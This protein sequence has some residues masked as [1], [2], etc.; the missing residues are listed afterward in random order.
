MGFVGD[1]LFIE[2]KTKQKVKARHVNYR[3]E[4]LYNFAC[5]FFDP[6]IV[7]LKKELSSFFNSLTGYIVI[8]VFLLINSLFLWVFPGE[9]NVLDSGYA[10][11]ETLFVL[12]PWVFLFLVPAVCMRL[13]SEEKRTGTIELIITRPLSELQVVLAKYLAG[14]GLVLFSLL[15][16]LIYFVSVY[17]LGNPV[18][19]ID[20][21]ATW[22]SYIGLFFLAG[23]YTSIGVFASSLTENQIVAFIIAM[24]LSFFFFIGFESVSTLG[25]FGKFDSFLINLGINEHYRSMSRGVLDTRDMMYFIGVIAVFIVS[26]KTVLES[27]KW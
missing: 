27:R 17:K 14:V 3:T 10:N 11:L 24:L 25:L 9:F 19:N 12:S 16:S 18:G 7:L 5:K 1:Q 2:F 4:I 8:L 22:G 6:M 20:T 23:I 15:P 21:G 26:T 13:F